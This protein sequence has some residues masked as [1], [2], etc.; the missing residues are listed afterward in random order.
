MVNFKYKELNSKFKIIVRSNNENHKSFTVKEIIPKI[1][2]I[3]KK[4]I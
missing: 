2:S 3:E 1:F 4:D